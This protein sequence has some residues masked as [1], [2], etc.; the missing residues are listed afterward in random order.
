MRS[1]WAVP[2]V[3]RFAHNPKEVTTVE[4]LLA[5]ED[6]A[7]AAVS[8]AWLFPSYS[9]ARRLP[10]SGPDRVL[11]PFKAVET[12]ES[13]KGGLVTVSHGLVWGRDGAVFTPAGQLIA[14]LSPVI[15]YGPRCHRVF[16][17]P[18]IQEPRRVS[19]TLAVATGPSWDNW[20]H[21]LYGIVP[22]L[23]LLR[24]AYPGF[25]GIDRIL[26]PPLSRDF[27]RETVRRLGI[28]DEMVI[29]ADGRTFLT[30]DQV[31]APTFISP[32]R[33]VTPWFA[34]DVN[35]LFSSQDDPGAGA[36]RLYISRDD[37]PGRH[38]V[39]ESDLLD[40]LKPFGFEKILLSALSLREQIAL[41]RTA[42][43][44]VG[45]HGA[46]LSN[47]V[48]CKPGTHVLEIFAPS[49]INAMYWC[50]ADEVGLVYRYCVGR[51]DRNGRTGREGMVRAD[52]RV[53]IPALLDTVKSL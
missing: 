46:G 32:A 28:S 11:E 16:V 40:A 15:R 37:A 8:A 14:D 3:R 26:L 30:A 52:V 53:D 36:R 43:V 23:M 7:R 6:G 27:Q 24:R 38:V 10:S 19:G 33:V 35:E 4:R 48:F 49:Y 12:A 29:T 42:S 2:L 31:V 44:V 34:A 18:L 25:R 21:W 1:V 9:G 20:S 22:R 17:Q 13:G 50:V 47:L 39:N 5:Q 41:F 51:G 45:T